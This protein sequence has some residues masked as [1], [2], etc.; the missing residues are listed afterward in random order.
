MNSV[1]QKQQTGQYIRRLREER[2]ETQIELAS[3]VGVERSAVCQWEKGKTMP[4]TRNLRELSKHFSV[5]FEDL[6][7]GGRQ[8]IVDPGT[9]QIL[10]SGRVM[11]DIFSSA[12]T[13]LWKKNSTEQGGENDDSENGDGTA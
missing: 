11:A 13:A 5:P 2:H 8:Q 1:E 7:D 4:S 3:A 6:L 12:Y 9:E 10:K